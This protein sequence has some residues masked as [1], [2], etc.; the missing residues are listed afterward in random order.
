MSCRSITRIVSEHVDPIVLKLNAERKNFLKVHVLARA[1]HLAA[2][3]VALIASAIDTIIG[4]GIGAL[5]ICTFGKN[6][7][8]V[9][10][11]FKLLSKSNNLI[12]RPYLH[13]LRFVNPRAK[14]KT[15]DLYERVVAVRFVHS[16]LELIA[17]SSKSSGNFLV[18]HVIGRLGTA[19]VALSRIVAQVVEG[20]ISIPLATLAIVTFGRNKYLNTLAHRTLLAPFIIGEI[21]ECWIKCINPQVW[22][23]LDRYQPRPLWI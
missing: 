11:A 14:F 2:S 17:E 18:R 3:P 16:K 12:A 4:L 20:M 15:S 21:V 10:I 13:L 6:E 22:Q 19:L 5:G 23:Q 1:A 7:E 9:R 8:L